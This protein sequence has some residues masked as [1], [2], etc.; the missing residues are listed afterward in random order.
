MRP[1]SIALADRRLRAE[2]PA[3][4]RWPVQH[5]LIA[6][7]EEYLDGISLQ[8][9]GI[10]QAELDW[11]AGDRPDGAPERARDLIERITSDRNPHLVTNLERT[12]SYI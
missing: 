6:A 3:L 5:A 2:L 7:G 12:N 4:I 10:T 8:L 9:V 11:V 1:P